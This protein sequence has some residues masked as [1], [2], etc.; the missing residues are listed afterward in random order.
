MSRSLLLDG[1]LAEDADAA[2]A[3]V[4]TFDHAAVLGEAR[5]RFLPGAG[6]APKNAIRHA[7]RDGLIRSIEPNDWRAAKLSRILRHLDL[8]FDASPSEAELVELCLQA[9]ARAVALLKR[10]QGRGNPK[11]GIEPFAGDSVV[12]LAR[13]V[14]RRMFEQLDQSFALKPIEERE[15]IAADIAQRLAEL[16]EDVRERIRS[17]AGLANL[18]AAALMR[19]G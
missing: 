1:I 14:M 3:H 19:T 10:L 8:R 17:E 16:P 13:F 12:D 5:R 9:E 11:K 15:R 4:W 2:R 18:S 7:R 6:S